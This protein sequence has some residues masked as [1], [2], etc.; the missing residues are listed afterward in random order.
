MQKLG[1][2]TRSFDNAC[3]QIENFVKAPDILKNGLYK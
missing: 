1:E 2:E 3:G